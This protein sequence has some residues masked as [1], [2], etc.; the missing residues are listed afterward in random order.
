MTP[1]SLLEFI[2]TGQPSGSTF[3]SHLVSGRGLDDSAPVDATNNNGVTALDFATEIGHTVISEMF[4]NKK[5][6]NL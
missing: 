4:S 2:I 6:Q 1:Y 3:T 5:K